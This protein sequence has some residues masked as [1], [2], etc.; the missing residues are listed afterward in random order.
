MI[1]QEIEK[2]GPKR[3][4]IARALFHKGVTI[5]DGIPEH[6]IEELRVAGYEIKKKKRNRRRPGKQTTS[7]K[8]NHEQG[9]K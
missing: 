5:W 7:D 9:A 1:H 4:A 6:I 8:S 3:A 2:L